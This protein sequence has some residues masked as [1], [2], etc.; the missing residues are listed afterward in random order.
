MSAVAD[1]TAMRATVATSCP[2]R[3][4]ALIEARVN[5]LH[6]LPA[7]H[8]PDDLDAAERC[9]LDVVE[10]F[11]ADVHAL[12]DAQFVALSQHYSPADVVAIMFHAGLCDGFAKHELAVVPA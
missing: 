9:M 2:G 6:G 3:T 5:Q 10:V 12:E 8:L 11:V 1:P 7:G 4:A